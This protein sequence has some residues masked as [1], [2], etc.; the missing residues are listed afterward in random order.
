MR[1]MRVVHREGWW[2]RRRTALR[3]AGGWDVCLGHLEHVREGAHQRD[4]RSPACQFGQERGVTADLRR[5]VDSDE[6]QSS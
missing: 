4:L 2:G 3:S 5:I 1:L 6:R